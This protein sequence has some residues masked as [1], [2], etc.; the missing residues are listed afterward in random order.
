[1]IPIAFS[2]LAPETNWTCW[3]TFGTS[4]YFIGIIGE[5]AADWQMVQFRL[6][7]NN[8]KKVCN[9]G[10]W[11]YSRH[12]NYFFE[13]IIWISY[14]V[15]AMNHPQGFIGWISPIMIIVSILK[16]TGIP[17]TEKRLLAS[18]GNAYRE[19]QR[20]TSAFIPMPPKGIL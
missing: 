7:A 17:P 9:T 16:V 15:I 5:W 8:R 11:Y 3:D 13:S 19:Y 14:A 6:D 10:L 4:L 18:K 1:M 20:T 2:F 12:P